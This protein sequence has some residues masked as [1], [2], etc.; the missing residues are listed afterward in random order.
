M[1]VCIRI[2]KMSNL[3]LCCLC[4][5]V[6]SA[7]RHEEHRH[8]SDKCCFVSPAPAK[9]STGKPEELLVEKL[10]MLAQ[11]RTSKLLSVLLIQHRWWTWGWLTSLWVYG[12]HN[13]CIWQKSSVSM[14]WINNVQG[15]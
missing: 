12:N 9:P 1:F 14:A 5:L 11:D 3:E 7:F 13:L 4:H 6:Q 15:N 10:E 8:I 2:S